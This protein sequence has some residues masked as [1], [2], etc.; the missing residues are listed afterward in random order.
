MALFLKLLLI[1]LVD[2]VD[3]LVVFIDILSTALVQVLK[4]SLELDPD[5]VQVFVIVL[6]DEIVEVG[7]EFKIN[8]LGIYE[9]RV[10]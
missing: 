6:F 9:N 4:N 2:E 3:N 10:L 7:I 8:F 5:S 1:L